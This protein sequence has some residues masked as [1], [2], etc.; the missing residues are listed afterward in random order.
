[1]FKKLLI[2][3]VIVINGGGTIIE[4]FKLI[5]KKYSL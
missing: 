5:S 1:M 4:T 2:D 3:L